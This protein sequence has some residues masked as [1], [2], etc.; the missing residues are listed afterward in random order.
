MNADTLIGAVFG[1]LVLLVPKLIG[2]FRAK[3]EEDRADSTAES[4]AELKEN[5]QALVI[6]RELFATYQANA[7]ERDTYVNRLLE[8]RLADREKIAALESE[9]KYLK[10]Q[11][12]DHAE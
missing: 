1:G 3:K 8:A 11:L 2:A 4:A 5:E 6:Y 12:R 9:L 7:L 10:R